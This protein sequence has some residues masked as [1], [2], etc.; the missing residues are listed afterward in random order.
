M[1][2]IAITSAITNS[3]CITHTPFFVFAGGKSGIF[4]AEPKRLFIPHCYKKFFLTLNPFSYLHSQLTILLTNP[5]SAVIPIY[6]LQNLVI[7]T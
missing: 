4:G 7:Y 1:I 6:N 2:G 3:H 5:A